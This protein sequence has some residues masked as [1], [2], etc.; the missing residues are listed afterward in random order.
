[1]DEVSIVVSGKQVVVSKVTPLY[2]SGYSFNLDEIT[3]ADVLKLLKEKIK[4]CF[5]K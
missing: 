4:S 2:A 3:V 1:M 5:L